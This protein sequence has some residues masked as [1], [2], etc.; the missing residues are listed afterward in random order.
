MGQDGS[1]DAEIPVVSRFLFMR[2]KEAALAKAA[3]G[4][5]EAK[6]HVHH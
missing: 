4:L 3:H 1:D 6:A 5:D 2:S